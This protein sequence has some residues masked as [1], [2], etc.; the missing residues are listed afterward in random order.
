MDLANLWSVKHCLIFT[1]WLGTSMG[2][3]IDGTLTTRNFLLITESK[4][5]LE[6]KKRMNI[7]LIYKNMHTLYLIAEKNLIFYTCTYKK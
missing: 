3:K 5:D 2:L 7:N 4:I 6:F 1:S